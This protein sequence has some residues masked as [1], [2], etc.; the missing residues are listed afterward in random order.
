MPGQVPPK[1]SKNTAKQDLQPLSLN[2]Q[3]T[4]AKDC[5]YETDEE[6]F[7]GVAEEVIPLE[8]GRRLDTTPPEVPVQSKHTTYGEE[9]THE[10]VDWEEIFLN[11]LEETRKLEKER[12]EKK[13][14]AEKKE[15]SWLLLR[16]CR[17]FLRE[18][19]KTWKFL[20]NE[21]PK[22]KKKQEDKN[23]RLELAKI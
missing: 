14:R 8:V 1:I 19:E 23:R 3:D 18:N 16:E 5:A 15:Q 11:H 9:K 7:G 12:Q 4:L 22:M 20:E 6:E 13:E 17:Q 2:T 21:K 10:L